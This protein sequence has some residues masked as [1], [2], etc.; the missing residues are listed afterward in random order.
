MK[1][2][3]INTDLHR[4]FI[5][6]SVYSESSVA[7]KSIKTVGICAQKMAN[8]KNF[9]LL[10]PH[11]VTRDER[12]ATTTIFASIAQAGAKRRSPHAFGGD[13]VNFNQK[14]MY[15]ERKIGFIQKFFILYSA[16]T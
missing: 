6:F 2:T 7:K 1:K 16:M 5:N 11:R 14:R 13:P 10:F 9:L 12:Q 15:P 4:F 8:L 3:W